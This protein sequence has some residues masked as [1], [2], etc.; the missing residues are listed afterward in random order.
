VNILAGR[1]VRVLCGKRMSVL[2]VIGILRQW[3]K[4]LTGRSVFRIDERYLIKVYANVYEA[5]YEHQ[6]L[7][8]AS[9]YKTTMFRIPKVFSL[10]KVSGGGA[11]IMEYIPG[12]SLDKHILRFLLRRDFSI[13]EIFYNIG[14]A[15]KEL[16]FL[17]LSAL[18][19]SN[20]PSTYGA[21]IENLLK[22]LDHAL[23]LRILTHRDYDKVMYAIRSVNENKVNEL[24]TCVN[25]HGEMYFTHILLTDDDTLVFVDFHNACKG[26][27]Y[28]D[29]AM[30]AVSLYAS[31][32]FLPWNPKV[33]TPLVKAFLK[34][35]FGK[36]LSEELSKAI[37]L[38]QLYV[39]LQE[40]LNYINALNS[41]E[42]LLKVKLP[43]M[44][45]LKRLKKAI[46][47][48]IL[49]QLTYASSV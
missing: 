33:F 35:Y 14:K 32:M 22:L 1:T 2:S 19:S 15:L 18:R 44:I 3:F 34:G 45:K 40:I 37:A 39:A 43:S 29:L 10:V 49:P 47:D 8:N 48:A 42:H 25:L 46:K 31:I 4:S 5:F 21:F 7:L 9:K 23:K 6:V 13:I 30:L 17:P 24:F 27:A 26:P 11:T 38:A 16:H 20:F 36:E 12:I 41:R 28:F